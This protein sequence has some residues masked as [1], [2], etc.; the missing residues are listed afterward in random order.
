[1]PQL[2]RFIS[3]TTT[4]TQFS[5]NKSLN[6]TLKIKKEGAGWICLRATPG[7][8]PSGV[9]AELWTILCQGSGVTPLSYH[10]HIAHPRGPASGARWR[11]KDCTVSGSSESGCPQGGTP[12]LRRR[13]PRAWAGHRRWNRQRTQVVALALFWFYP[14][15]GDR[16]AQNQMNFSIAWMSLLDWSSGLFALLIINPWIHLPP[17]LWV[18]VGP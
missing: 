7:T 17:F 2:R 8:T 3:R 16:A 4:K 10:C 5:Q 18:R 1:M 6:K 11:S 13:Q 15:C 12:G 9:S 14:G